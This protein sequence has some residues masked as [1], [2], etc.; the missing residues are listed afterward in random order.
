MRAEASLLP[1]PFSFLRAAGI[2]LTNI[3]RVARI[4]PLRGSPVSVMPQINKIAAGSP[5]QSHPPQVSRVGSLTGASIIW[6][7]AWRSDIFSSSSS[8]LLIVQYTKLNLVRH[9]D[10]VVDYGGRGRE[11]HGDKV[12]LSRLALAPSHCVVKAH[13]HGNLPLAPFFHSHFRRCHP[14]CVV[15]QWPQILS[16]NSIRAASPVGCAHGSHMK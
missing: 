2:T 14:R 9:L 7:V 4:L 11:P 16:T 15:C 13:K 5:C 1:S 8:R 10:V 12:V 6:V 3:T